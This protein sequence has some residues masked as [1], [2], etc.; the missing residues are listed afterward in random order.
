MA[1]PA[2]QLV[3]GRLEPEADRR[4]LVDLRIERRRQRRSPDDAVLDQRVQARRE[5]GGDD[6]IEAGGQ[7]AKALG[8]QEQLADDE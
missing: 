1:A 6:V 7:V 3:D 8:S 2:D 5:D 4:Q